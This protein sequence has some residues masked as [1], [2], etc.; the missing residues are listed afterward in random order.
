MP[1]PKMAIRR[2]RRRIGHGCKIQESRGR[3]QESELQ[4]GSLIPDSWSN[5]FGQHEKHH[6]NGE[7]ETGHSPAPAER[8]PKDLIPVIETGGAVN[9]A[10]DDDQDGK[11]PINAHGCARR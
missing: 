1:T 7:Q 4:Y 11:L 3:S 9:Q 6:S 2:W 5:D 10:D 8:F